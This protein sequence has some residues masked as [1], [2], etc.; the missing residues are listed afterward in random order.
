MCCCLDARQY[1]TLYDAI[2]SSVPGFPLLYHLLKLVQTQIPLSRWCHPTISSCHPFSSCPPPFW[3]SGSFPM[4]QLFTS[5]GRSVGALAASVLLLNIQG[6]SPLGLTGMISLQSKRH[7]C[8][9]Q[10]NNLEASVFQ[11]SAF[12]VQLSYL[13]MTAGKL[14]LYG[15][16]LAKWYLCLF[17]FLGRIHF[18]GVISFNSI[19]T[20][21]I[22]STC[23]QYKI[24][25]VRASFFEGL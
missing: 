25:E 13:Y 3:A 15:P 9:L 8:L 11:C 14:W 7:K 24:I 4:S 22:I 19:Y 20:N 18:N 5:G 6:W 2:D 16:L 21:I 12:M 17:F 1:S 23:N 10:H